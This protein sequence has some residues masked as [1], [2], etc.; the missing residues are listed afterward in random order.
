MKVVLFAQGNKY[1]RSLTIQGIR[2]QTYP[3]TIS[4]RGALQQGA[5][6]ES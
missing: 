4:H 6:G 2:L 3:M 1:D 5:A